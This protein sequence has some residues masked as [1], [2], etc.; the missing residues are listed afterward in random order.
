MRQI[1]ILLTVTASLQKIV[2]AFAAGPVAATSLEKR[3]AFIAAPGLNVARL[4]QFW[5]AS[6]FAMP[7]ITPLARPTTAY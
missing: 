7:Q 5:P 4:A 3:I 2:I 6:R 1:E